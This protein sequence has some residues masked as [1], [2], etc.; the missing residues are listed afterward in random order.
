[1]ETTQL[2]ITAATTLGVAV[3][4]AMAV[5]PAALE[6]GSASGDLPGIAGRLSR[7]PWRKGGRGRQGEANHSH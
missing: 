7:L 5:V 1:M 3:V 4:G 2:L 6:A